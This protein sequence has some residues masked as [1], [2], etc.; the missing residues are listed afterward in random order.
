MILLFLLSLLLWFGFFCF[1]LLVLA[2]PI[3][4]P[5]FLVFLISFNFKEIQGLQIQFEYAPIQRPVLRMPHHVSNFAKQNSGNQT[6]SSIVH[7][8]GICPYSITPL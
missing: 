1:E 2:S 4:T 3:P 8:K 5:G 6:L 7:S